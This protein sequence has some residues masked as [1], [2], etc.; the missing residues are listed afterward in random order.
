M[1]SE[2]QVE[3]NPTSGVTVDLRIRP[4]ATSVRPETVTAM[5]DFIRAW[6]PA[7]RTAHPA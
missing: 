1:A 4:D 2:V 5:G 3:T 7:G 6:T